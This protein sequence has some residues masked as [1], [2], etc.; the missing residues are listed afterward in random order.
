[1]TQYLFA[2]L[3][4]AAPALSFAAQSYPARPVRIVVPVPA[5]GGVDSLARVVGQHLN[6]VWGQPFIVDN[7][8]GAGGSLGADIVARATPDGYTLMVS[9]SSYVTNAAVR[10]TPYDPIRDFQPITKLTTNPYILV[11]T[12]SFPVKTVNDVV[13]LAKSKPGA[14][15]YSS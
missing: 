10:K 6:A 14:I 15:K 8:P 1:M 13:A 5:G 2:V 12:P 4:L 11:V 9:S 7:R 3:L